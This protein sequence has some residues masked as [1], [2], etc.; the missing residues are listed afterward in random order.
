MRVF[1][2]DSNQRPLD[3]CPPARARY[4]LNQ[5]RAAVFRRF[6]FT[7]ILK[8]RLAEESTVHPHRVKVDPGSKI[9]GMALVSQIS[10][11]VV[12]AAEIEHRGNVIKAAMKARAA[13]R[14]NRRSRKT[15]YRQRR[16]LNRSRPKGWLPPSLKSRLFNVLTWVQR[17]IRLCPI[18][19]IRACYELRW[20]N[21]VTPSRT[22]TCARE[23]PNDFGAI[24]PVLTRSWARF[25]TRSSQEL[26]RFDLQKMENPGISGIEYQQ[27]TRSGYE[28]REY[29]LEKWQRTCAYC[30][31]TGIPLQVEHIQPRSRG[32]TDRI[33]NLAL[34]CEPC[35]R[36]K[37]NRAIEVFL[38]TKPEVLARIQ[39]Q[40]KQPLRGAAA[41]NITRW[42][43]WRRLTATG[44]SVECGSGG[45]TKFNRTTQGLPKTHW[46]DAACVGSSTPKLLR[47]KEI[48]PLLIKAYGHGTRQRC[49]TDRYGFPRCHVTVGKTNFG[50]QTGDIVRAFVQAGKHQGIHEGR[51]VI[52][53]VPRFKLGEFNVHPRDLVIIHRADGYRYAYG[54]FF[55][56]SS[57]E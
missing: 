46:I 49:Q 35:N 39:Q 19:A 7:I 48:R 55:D 23:T 26:V 5:N 11:Q 38:K 20:E 57:M 54:K 24:N 41:V 22:K 3:P 8:D 34:A 32:G 6:P 40:V 10:G 12:F 37:G 15:R 29:L 25:I 44:L 33:S 50:F 4:L 56:L 47:I 30:G 27:G 31:K 53:S 17:L 13:L 28:V 45:Q 52:R 16:F 1:V 14:H 9:T 43:L 18:T 42:E 21:D 2:L 36:R 51:I